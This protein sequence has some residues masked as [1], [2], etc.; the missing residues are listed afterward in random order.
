[1]EEQIV[2]YEIAV[3]SKEAGFKWNTTYEFEDSKPITYRE[4]IPHDYNSRGLLSA[5]TQ[6][7][8]Q[9]WFREEHNIFIDITYSPTNGGKKITL[10]RPK[11]EKEIKKGWNSLERVGVIQTHETYEQALEEGLRLAFKIIGYE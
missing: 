6:S 5:P 1:M 3:L 10:W 9:K 11:T 4:Y 7:L 2:S 8:L